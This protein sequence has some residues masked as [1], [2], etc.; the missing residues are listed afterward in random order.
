MGWLAPGLFHPSVGVVLCCSGQ[1]L[2]GSGVVIIIL[3]TCISPGCGEGR[4]V[5]GISYVR[6]AV[7]QDC[8]HL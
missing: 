3:K 6:V 5:G 4:G 8:I 1:C 2:R 7:V